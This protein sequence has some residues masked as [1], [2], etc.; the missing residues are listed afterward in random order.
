MP[1]IDLQTLLELGAI[2]FALVVYAI[3][4][5]QHHNRAMERMTD[6]LSEHIK[7]EDTI[8][9]TLADALRE[10]LSG[11][12]ELRNLSSQTARLQKETLDELKQFR[13]EVAEIE[14]ATIEARTKMIVMLDRLVPKQ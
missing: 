1:E 4:Q 14:R 12:A 3:R 11:Q 8:T 9:K 5:E 7:N 6:M 2:L 10:L 13:K